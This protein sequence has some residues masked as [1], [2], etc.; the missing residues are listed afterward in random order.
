MVYYISF[1]PLIH[2]S[3]EH[4]NTQI[5]TP[6]ICGFI[7]QLVRASHGHREVRGSNPV[8]VLNFVRLLYAIAKIAF[9]T[10]RIT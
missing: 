8:V 7:G 9:I 2:L 10:V 5:T 6:T 3:R 4:L 1:H